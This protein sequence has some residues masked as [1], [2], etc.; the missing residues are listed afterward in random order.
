MAIVDYEYAR[1]RY[2]WSK[3]LNWITAGV[4]VALGAW[5]LYYGVG[6]YLDWQWLNQ[7]FSG[8]GSSRWTPGAI[9][10]KLTYAVLALVAGALGILTFLICIL[11]VR[12]A[13]DEDS[14]DKVRRWSFLAGITGILPGALFGGLLEIFIWRAHTQESFTMFGLLGSA[15]EV[16]PEAPAGPAPDV[17]AAQIEAQRKAEYAAL[18]GGP[19]SAPAPDYGY[20]TPAADPY[21]PAYDTGVAE[22]PAPDYGYSAGAEAASAQAPAEASG[23]YYDQPT[24]APICTC[25]RPMEW[26]AEYNRYYCYTDDKYEGET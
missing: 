20:E 8:G 9:N 22:A 7:H 11:F 21:A 10:L 17:V 13:L 1:R 12:K 18:F 6:A 15:P 3:R 14:T 4:C 19:S 2:S 5:A 23:Q 25:G 26:V 16:A 24:G